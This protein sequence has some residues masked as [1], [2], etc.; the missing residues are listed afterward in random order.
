MEPNA[1]ELSPIRDMFIK[2]TKDFE[3][4]LSD[5][6]GSQYVLQEDPIRISL[7]E[8]II[9]DIPSEARICGVCGAG[10]ANLHFNCKH[11]FHSQCLPKTAELHKCH[12]CSSDKIVPVKAYCHICERRYAHLDRVEPHHHYICRTCEEK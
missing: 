12:E 10:K 5:Q 9:D 11:K 4:K 7:S 2:T 8:E 6:A 1:G 3:L